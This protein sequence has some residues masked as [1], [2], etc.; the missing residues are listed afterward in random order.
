M[1]VAETRTVALDIPTE[2]LT[3]NKYCL[4]VVDGPDRGHSHTFQKRQ[5]SIG[6]DRSCD[7]QLTDPTVSRVHAFLE[8][9]A[10][11][12]RLKDDNSKNGIFINDIRVFEAIILDG[13][14]FSVGK[15]RI[16][17]SRIA[18]TVSIS[19]AT[20]G[21][22]G[23]MLG[24]SMEMREVFAII[25]KVGPTDSNVLIQGESGTGKE[26]V[27][28]A[29]H[30]S[31]P[32]AR[33]PFIVFD[34]SAVP[35]ELM[36]SEL[37]GHVRGA[38]TG[39]VRDRIGAIADAEGG[40]LFLDEIGELP[41][42]LQPKLLRVLESRE[43]RQVGGNRVC[44]VNFRLVCATNRFLEQ[45]VAAGNFRSDLYYRLGVITV[46]LP[47]LRRRPQDIPLLVN[48]FLDEIVAREGG[49]R[50]RLS[51]ETMEKLKKLPWPGNVRELK[52]FVER[53]V[54]LSGALGGT[55]RALDIPVPQ[56]GPI[57]IPGGPEDSLRV[58]FD[59]PFKQ[60]KE[61]LIDEFQRRYFTRLLR[62]TDGNI[63]KAARLAGIHRKSL[64]YL[65]K[66][67]EPDR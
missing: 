20:A 39:A 15:T 18:E 29:I 2:D 53:S 43:V 24:E 59:A 38:F 48:H 21:R 62:Q 36:E 11:G 12:F 52:N 10:S 30:Q 66:N 37:F 14:E 58:E 22:F 44:K 54:I 65:L 8:F 31:G 17:F 50:V 28:D 56:T 67:I 60:E 3:F 25:K 64:E 13:T 49:S 47:P 40:T 57:C 9:G 51:W 35:P 1:S 23:N 33:G 19:I 46:A 5:I 63:S 27:A 34:C 41:L 55:P 32:R 26:L 4:K 45:E 42:E 7:L 6:T 61:R 16:Q